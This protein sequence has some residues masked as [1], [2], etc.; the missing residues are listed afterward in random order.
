[1]CLLTRII[2]IEVVDRSSHCVL[3]DFCA[4][5][6]KLTIAILFIVAI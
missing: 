5:D 4:G 1:M 2:K 3:R 6:Y